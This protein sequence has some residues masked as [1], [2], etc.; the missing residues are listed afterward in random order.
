M[1]GRRSR[2]RKRPLHV[3]VHQ[4]QDYLFFSEQRPPNPALPTQE[5]QQTLAV[6]SR[7]EE[8]A[9]EE[10]P[11]VSLLD[12][13]IQILPPQLGTAVNSNWPFLWPRYLKK[14][15]P[16]LSSS[17]LLSPSFCIGRFSL[18]LMTSGLRYLLSLVHLT[19]PQLKLSLLPYGCD[20]WGYL[21]LSRED[22][23]S[24]YILFTASPPFSEWCHCLKSTGVYRTQLVLKFGERE[25]KCYNVEQSSTSDSGM[26][27]SESGGDGEMKS[28][29][30]GT[31]TCGV[32]VDVS[33]GGLSSDKRKEQAVLVGG[34]G[35][36]GVNEQTG[37]VGSG[38]GARV[39][40]GDGDCESVCVDVWVGGGVCVPSDPNSE[41]L[42]GNMSKLTHLVRVLHPG[43]MIEKTTPTQS[44]W[45][46]G[47]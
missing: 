15:V 18:S 20:D 39:C 31:T 28:E 36:G 14:S 37:E 27:D 32:G 8:E 2:K 29:A 33:L 40:E 4:S 16:F 12:Q 11:T 19:E 42:G 9:N 45:L 5:Q 43:V 10:V 46:P 44:L 30:N 25:R 21:E 1:P 17:S 24:V 6:A 38:A 22:G 13:L 7:G 35:G 47:I 26:G 3:N 23:E 41:P 34:E